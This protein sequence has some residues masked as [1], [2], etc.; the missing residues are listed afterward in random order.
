M[1]PAPVRHVEGGDGRLPPAGDGALRQRRLRDRGADRP[2][3]RGDDRVGGPRRAA[4]PARDPARRRGGVAPGRALA[5]PRAG[6]GGRRRRARVRVHD[7]RPRAHRQHLRAGERGVRA[8]HGAPRLHA[9]PDDHRGTGARRSRSWSWPG[10]AG[11]RAAAVGDIERADG[12]RARGRRPLHRH[13]ARRLG[14]LGPLRRVRGRAGPAGGGSGE[15][16]G[17]SGELLL[18]LPLRGVVRP[19]RAGGHAAA[20]RAAPCWPSASP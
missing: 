2:G 14:D 17:P 15:P 11:R 10:S 6:H 9:L 12:G 4:L 19:G 5:R 8:G 1:V 13:G 16:P 20:Q 7:G 18:P 3:Q